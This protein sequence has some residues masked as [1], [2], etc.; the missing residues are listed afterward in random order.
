MRNLVIGVNH[1]KRD[2]TRVETE[3]LAGAIEDF[4][5]FERVTQDINEMKRLGRP[6]SRVIWRYIGVC[7]APNFI[8]VCVSAIPSFAAR[9][10][11]K[12]VG[13]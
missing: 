7:F 11:L 10:L 5:Q 9:I 1:W 13:H 2:P 4:E 12:M 8:T 6:T 3:A